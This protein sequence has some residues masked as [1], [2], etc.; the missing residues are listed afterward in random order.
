MER[1]FAEL[2]DETEGEERSWREQAHVVFLTVLSAGLRRGEILGLRWRHV[3]LT[4]PDGARLR[5][6]ETWVRG[7]PDTP[8][9]KKSERTIALG[10]RLTSELFDHRGRTWFEGADAGVLL[11][12]RRATRSRPLRGHVAARAQAGEY[13]QAAAA[14]PRRPAHVDHERGRGRNV[15]RRADGTGRTLR[16]E[17]YAGVHRPRRRDVPR[18]GPALLE[19]RLF[20]QKSGQN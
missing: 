19:E 11:A 2:I 1:A 20:G 17:D 18:R 14:V 5:V 3:S 15:A 8:K 13:R 9:S 4:D 7:G 6:E 12:D 16:L 10:E